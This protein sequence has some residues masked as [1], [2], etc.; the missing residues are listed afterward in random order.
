MY[1]FLSFL[2][3]IAVFYVLRFFP[4]TISLILIPATALLVF[5]K[6][7]LYALVIVL[8]FFY[9]YL[10]YVPAIDFSA[11]SGRELLIKCSSET[12]PRELPSGRFANDVKI[13][14]A[15]DADAGG[16]LKGMEGVVMSIVSD[17]GLKDRTRYELLVKT[18]KDME[19]LDPGAVNENRLYADLEEV[20]KTEGLRANPFS[21]WLDGRRAMLNRF[22][23]NNFNADSGAF[24][25]AITTGERTAMGDA[26]KKRF[27]STGLAHLLSISGTHFGL[28]S[29]FIFGICRLLIKLMP[30]RLL[31]RLTIYLTPSQTA[32]IFSLPFVL[33]YLLISGHNIPALRSFIMINIFL[34]GLIIGRKG[35]W[36][37]S[38]L[39]AGFVICAWDPSALLGVSFQLSFLAVFF[40]GLF[41][42][43]K[44]NGGKKDRG[45][46]S[47]L[48]GIF[49]NTLLLSLSASLGTALLVAYYFHYFSIISPISNFF[50]TPFTG[51]VLVPVSLISSF[52][53]I[54]T[55]YFPFQSLIAFLSGITIEG[56]RLF[57][58]VP[59]ADIKIPSFPLIAVVAFYSG[60]AVYFLS[61]RRR[62]ILIL[63][64]VSVAVLLAPLLHKNS[65]S[66]TYLDVG[67]GDS[68]VIETIGHKVIVIDTGSTGKELDSYLRYAGKRTIEA[69][70]LSHADDDHSGG[71]SHIIENYPVGEIWDNGLLVYPKGF[72]DNICR[73][74]LER[75]DVATI[76]TMKVTVLHPYRGF[77]T[78]A[79]DEAASENNESL[80]LK[81][82]EGKNSFLFTGDAAEEAEADMTHLGNWLKSDV[83]K[84]SHHGSRTSSTEDFLQTVSPKIAV[85]SVG[86]QNHYGH[87]HAETLERLQG[88]RVFRTDRDGAVK[89]TDTPSGPEVKTYRDFQF[90]KVDGFAGELRNIKR[91]FVRW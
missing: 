27:N 31:R 33:L 34:L 10:R 72:L 50:I 16:P 60:L 51:F 69:L 90:E 6:R 71:A 17:R 18:W 87:P 83:I 65:F 91:L 23:K 12:S 44:K 67:Q 54:F 19:R 7:Y 14:A 40:I 29:I 15:S 21:K 80:V 52:V 74:T 62:S 73:R 68:A 58:S 22:F 86:R 57:A 39:F 30:L 41:A 82:T 76:D 79:D 78:F 9:A 55:G 32:A 37:N 46:I 85:I 38:L 64:A 84:V 13:I 1:I 66:V 3:G 59:Y 81:I 8:G 43:R 89:I 36:L 61:G 48:T 24:L 42:G 2:S 25:S 49:K 56:V 35:F 4:F 70:V 28:F 26:M 20:G 88:I 45:F 53:F 47:R 77:Y 75:G 5:R 11:L 63:P